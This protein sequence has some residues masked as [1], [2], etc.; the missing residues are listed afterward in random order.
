MRERH[1]SLR[2]LAE[3]E[4]TWGL[5]AKLLRASRVTGPKVHDA[6]I[7]AICMSHAVEE[8]WFADRD[9]SRFKG[10]AVRNPLTR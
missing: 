3:D 7:V 5:H 1:P 10:L 6:R 4:T 8:L 9:F 2:L